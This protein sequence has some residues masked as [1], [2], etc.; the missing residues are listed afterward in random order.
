MQVG[1]FKRPGR[2]MS[3]GRLEA[4]TGDMLGWLQCDTKVACEE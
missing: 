1:E 4:G 3:W 2:H